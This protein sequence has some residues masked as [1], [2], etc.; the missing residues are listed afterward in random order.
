MTVLYYPLLPQNRLVLYLHV[1]PG[2][3]LTFFAN[4]S[5]PQLGSP[6]HLIPFLAQE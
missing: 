2:A 5:L 1:A 4:A 6:I 3:G